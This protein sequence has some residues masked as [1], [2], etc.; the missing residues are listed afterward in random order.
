MQP[1]AESATHYAPGEV[2][3]SQGD[4]AEQVMYLESGCIKLSVLSSAGKFGVIAMLNSCQF[5]GEGALAGQP[6]RTA[7][8]RAVG[9]CSVISVAKTAMAALLYRP[10]DVSSRFIA[11]ILNRNVR[12]EDDLIDHLF[13]PAEKRLARTLLLLAKDLSEGAPLVTVPPIAQETLAE[14]IGTTRSR[15][16][17]FLNRFKSLGFIEYQAGQPLTVNTTLLTALLYD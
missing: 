10:D 4:R 2:I 9:Q 6:Y 5:F 8:A 3:Y 15:V 14:M 17:F 16:N 13:H 1:L 11:H 7:T 12:I